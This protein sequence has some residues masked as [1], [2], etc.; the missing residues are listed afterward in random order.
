MI[1]ESPKRM[2][3]CGGELGGGWRASLPSLLA[4][5]AKPI[6]EFNQPRNRLIRGKEIG[7]APKKS[8]VRKGAHKRSASKR[9]S[10]LDGG[11]G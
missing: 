5:A 3:A 2:C 6:A 9:R 8:E 11:V 10:G 4:A 1:S 7:G